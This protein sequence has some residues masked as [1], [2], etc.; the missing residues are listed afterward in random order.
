MMTTTA[1]SLTLLHPHLKKKALP[2]IRGEEPHENLRSG[3]VTQHMEAGGSA[4]SY[5]GPEPR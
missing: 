5:Q 4:I 1:A 3:Q 2:L